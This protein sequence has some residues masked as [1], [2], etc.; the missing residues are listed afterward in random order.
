ME[1]DYDFQDGDCFYLSNFE[2]ESDH[3]LELDD[4]IY[5][6]DF[7]EDLEYVVGVEEFLQGTRGGGG[8]FASTSTLEGAY[9]QHSDSKLEYEG[10]EEDGGRH[11]DFASDN[12][13]EF[14]DEPCLPSF[15]DVPIETF[16]KY[17]HFTITSKQLMIDC[18]KE[19]IFPTFDQTCKV[20]VCFR[21]PAKLHGR[22]IDANDT[23]HTT[24]RWQNFKKN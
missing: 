1:E 12:F 11:A 20:D 2:E 5:A 7:E 24:K 8:A 9:F 10:D 14:L 16:P 15:E 17:D 19:G 6:S 18:L 23:F 3:V 4:Y 21:P 22:S 13:C